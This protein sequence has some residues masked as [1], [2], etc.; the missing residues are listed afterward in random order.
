MVALL[1][2]N[3]LENQGITTILVHLGGAW[4]SLDLDWGLAHMVAIALAMLA[5]SSLT[6][7]ATLLAARLA[8]LAGR[9][10]VESIA[11]AVVLGVA[12]WTRWTR[13][14]LA[15]S[16]ATHTLVLASVGVLAVTVFCASR[17]AHIGDVREATVQRTFFAVSII[18]AY[19]TQWIT[20]EHTFFNFTTL[21][22]L[23][24]SV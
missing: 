20:E 15:R 23:A 10:A 19:I 18:S 13:W 7:R 12:A 14:K 3:T 21:L 9:V 5:S 17:C 4:R 6:G 1:G 22:V 24:I 16:N 2:S 11:A 8:S